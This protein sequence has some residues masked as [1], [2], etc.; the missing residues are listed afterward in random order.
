MNNLIHKLIFYENCLHLNTVL[1][2]VKIKNIKNDNKV[3]DITSRKPPTRF[4]IIL[5]LKCI[6]MYKEYYEPAI[7]YTVSQ[8]EK[9]S[10][11]MYNMN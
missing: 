3:H 7:M 10:S 6:I 1:K 11:E 5:V 2:D 4:T 8:E 9:R